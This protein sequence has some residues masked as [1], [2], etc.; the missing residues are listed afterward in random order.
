MTCIRNFCFYTV[1]I[2]TKVKASL[3]SNDFIITLS[4]TVFI[5]SFVFLV[6]TFL[7]D[8]NLQ[9]ISI[10]VQIKSFHTSFSEWFAK[11]KSDFYDGGVDGCGIKES[12]TTKTF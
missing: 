1:L 6:S 10:Y 7:L 4:D 3:D 9:A 2:V 11:G 5:H 8:T 12:C